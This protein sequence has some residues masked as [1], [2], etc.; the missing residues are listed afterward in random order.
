M[1]EKQTLIKGGLAVL[2]L[3]C[4]LGLPYG[5]FMLVRI[6]ALIVFGILAMQA[7]QD[8]EETSMYIYIG[9]AILFQPFFKIALGRDLWNIIDVVV[10]IGLI[11]S[12]FKNRK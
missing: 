11:V 5:F 1:R 9:L 2:L 12:I 4:L 7:H 6:V 8:K 3:M 10:A